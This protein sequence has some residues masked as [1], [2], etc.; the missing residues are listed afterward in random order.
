MLPTDRP[1]DAII[2]DDAK[3][4]RW[5]EHFMRDTARKLSRRAGG[6]QRGDPDLVFGRDTPDDRAQL[7]F[8][9]PQSK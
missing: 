5:F 6:P 9:P 7:V 3:L 4:D 2:Q 1:D 8:A